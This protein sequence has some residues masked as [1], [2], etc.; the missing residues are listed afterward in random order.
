MLFLEFVRYILLPIFAF[1]ATESKLR[2]GDNQDLF[3][4]GNEIEP[5]NHR[6]NGEPGGKKN[7]EE[8]LKVDR[9]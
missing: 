4:T 3:G 7:K 9:S 2:I 6:H 1:P 5:L 8:K